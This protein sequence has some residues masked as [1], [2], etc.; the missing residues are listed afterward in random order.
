MTVSLATPYR[1][2]IL[3][4]L[5]VLSECEWTHLSDHEPNPADARAAIGADIAALGPG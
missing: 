3:D 4:H 2:A 5:S 1:P